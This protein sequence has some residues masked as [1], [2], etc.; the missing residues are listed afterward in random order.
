MT[1]PTI[2]NVFALLDDWRGFPAYQL[3][4]RADIYFALFLPL[5]LKNH[6]DDL[7]T[8]PKLIPEFPLRHGT[9][10]IKQRGN[11]SSKVDYAAISRDDG[12]VYLIELKTDKES[13]NEEQ[14]NYLQAASKRTFKE[15]ADGVHR[16]SKATN[17]K[18]KYENLLERLTEIGAV[19]SAVKP[20]IV[21]LQPTKDNPPASTG[22]ASYIYFAEF[23]RF[24]RGR[25]EIADRF[26]KS[27]KEWQER[28]A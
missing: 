12:K 26:A 22:D 28:P 17:Q 19:D 20:Q 2:D 8:E 3:E 13:R 21:Y 15:L 18:H 25:G 11:R 4:R 27:L 10:G 23:A 9:L 6:F 16:I 1:N 14:D 24:I 7:K 5:V